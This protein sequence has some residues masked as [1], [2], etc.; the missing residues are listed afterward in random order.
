MRAA[1]VQGALSRRSSAS[2]PTLSRNLELQERDRSIVGTL[3]VQLEVRN[4]TLGD[5]E[6]LGNGAGFCG[7]R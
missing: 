3:T 1:G 2:S 4:F 6:V 5:Y 7:S